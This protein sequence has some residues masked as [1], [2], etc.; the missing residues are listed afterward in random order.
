MDDEITIPIKVIANNRLEEVLVS[1]SPSKSPSKRV[2]FKNPTDEFKN[3]NR[4]KKKRA[5]S[6]PRDSL[7]SRM[8][9]GNP[10]SRRFQRFLNNTVLTDDEGEDTD[11]DE[12]IA[13]DEKEFFEEYHSPF[14]ALHE[15]SEL[16]NAFSSFININPDDEH[17]ILKVLEESE[18]SIPGKTNKKSNRSK[19][20]RRRCSSSTTDIST[21][22]IFDAESRKTLKKYSHSD[23]LPALENELID[24]IQNTQIFDDL[25][26]NYERDNEH[27]TV[28]YDNS[29]CQLIFIFKQS[30]HRLVAHS[31]CRYFGLNSKSENHKDFGRVTIVELFD[32]DVPIELPEYPIRDYLNLC[33]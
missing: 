9:V 33:C 18:L 13:Q 30:F 7:A 4:K 27:F 21:N 14:K 15:D 26:S 28:S 1:Q 3:S 31:L 6:G 10:G 22:S 24:F 32:N 20:N 11:I 16:M 25:I 23:F 12:I 17:E 8:K 29:C 5:L 2:T 19:K